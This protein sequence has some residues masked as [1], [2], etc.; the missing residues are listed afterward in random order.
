MVSRLP[1]CCFDPTVNETNAVGRP[2]APKWRKTLGVDGRSQ[3]MKTAYEGKDERMRVYASALGVA[4]LILCAGG[5]AAA[6]AGNAAAGKTLAEA[7]CASCH[8][9]SPNQK[10]ATT[11]APPFT[12]IAKRPVEEIEELDAF[13]AAPHPP[14]P[15]VSLTR[16]EIRDIVAYIISLKE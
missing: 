6:A 1:K 8:L 15:P 7:S 10:S 13:L 4:A 9:V 5:S 2:A 12:T 16:Q 14:M 3:V 11:E